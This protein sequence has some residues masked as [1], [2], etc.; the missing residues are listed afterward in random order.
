MY[1]DESF[2][3]LRLRVVADADPVAIGAV[4]KRFQN[5]NVVP[6]RVSAEFGVDGRLH[7]EVDVCGVTGEQLSLITSK[8]NQSP[9]IHNAYWHP[10]A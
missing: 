9:C 8:V 5:L 6:R 10:L 3:L 4:V 7:I 1:P 2:S